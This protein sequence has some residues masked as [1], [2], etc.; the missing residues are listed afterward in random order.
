MESHAAYTVIKEL[1]EKADEAYAYLLHLKVAPELARTV[2]PQGMY[3][4]F[5]ET[6]SLY[7]YARLCKLRLDPQ[8]QK[9]IRDYATQLDGLLRLAFPVSWNA[10]IG[11]A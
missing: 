9:E 3:T 4:E 11:D 2:L 5:I 7:A 8:A 6:A 10:L 1:N